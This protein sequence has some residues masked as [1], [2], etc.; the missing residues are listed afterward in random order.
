MIK[1]KS[2][3]KSFFFSRLG[4]WWHREDGRGKFAA[5]DSSGT[6]S[7]MLYYLVETGQDQ[8]SFDF[9]GQ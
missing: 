7:E 1:I 2:Q 8:A 5:A 6:S 9:I 4:T 3:A